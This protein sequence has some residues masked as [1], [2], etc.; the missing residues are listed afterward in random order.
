MKAYKFTGET[1]FINGHVV[2]QICA[3]KDIHI[4]NV[5]RYG[6][7]LDIKAGSIGGWIESEENLSHNGECWVGE[8]AIVY[9]N[10]FVNQGAYVSGWARIRDEA[11]IT[12]NAWV[13]G[14]AYIRGHSLVTENASV[15]DNAEITGRSCIKG[16]ASIGGK[17][18]VINNTVTMGLHVGNYEM[19]G[20]EYPVG[21]EPEP[22]LPVDRSLSYYEIHQDEFSRIINNIYYRDGYHGW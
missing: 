2:H 9:E 13:D 21:R 8:N 14:R 4:R 15:D 19:D 22:P 12:G 17:V 10:A 18:R 11:V 7:N 6:M 5:G 16:D 1:D 3:L 20:T